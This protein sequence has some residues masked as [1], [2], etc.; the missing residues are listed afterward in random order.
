MIAFRKS[1]SILHLD[2]HLTTLDRYGYGYPDISYHGEEAWK[3]QWESDNRHVG[4]MYCG[5]SASGEKGDYIYIAYNMHWNSHRFALPSIANHAWVSQISTEP[6][7]VVYDEEKNMEY[8][9]IA[10]RSIS[11]LVGRTL[12]EEEKM[13]KQKTSVQTKDASPASNKKKK[14][15]NQKR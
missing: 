1:H 12:T 3:V 7:R 13:Q 15:K 6:N 4:M 8:I 2:E 10:P 9:D 5:K 11:I 14:A